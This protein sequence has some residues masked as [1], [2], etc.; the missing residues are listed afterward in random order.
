M[1]G[2]TGINNVMVG[3]V[4]WDRGWGGAGGGVVVKGVNGTEWACAQ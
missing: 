1:E 2:R 3:R 4:R